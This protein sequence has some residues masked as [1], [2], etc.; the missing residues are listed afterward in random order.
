MHNQ[1]PMYLMDQFHGVID[2]TNYN[3]RNNDINL[4]LPKPNTDYLK[5]CFIYQGIQAWNA[6]STE[7]RMQTSVN[8]FKKKL[9]VSPPIDTL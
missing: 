8:N 9:N 4:K 1:A 2:T 3:L 6:L 7:I 5:K